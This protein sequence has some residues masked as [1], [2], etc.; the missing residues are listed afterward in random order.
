MS[1]SCPVMTYQNVSPA[2]WTAILAQANQT[3]Q[4]YGIGPIAG[5]AGTQSHDG[6]TV[7]WVYN[8]TPG[9]KNCGNLTIAVTASD[10][11]IFLKPDI[12][13]QAAQALNFIPGL[14][15]ANPCP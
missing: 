5:N 14:I 10:F 8:P 6:V 9:Q 4:P 2:A 13:N 7:T 12:C 11:V 3:L 1:T 15:G